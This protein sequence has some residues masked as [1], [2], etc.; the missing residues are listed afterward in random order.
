M[1]GRDVAFSVSSGDGS[2]QSAAATTDSNGVAT[3]WFIFGN[4]TA[5]VRAEAL[6]ALATY[7]FQEP[8]SSSCTCGHGNCAG[9]LCTGA[10]DPG[11]CVEGWLQ[12]E[13][14][15]R[16]ELGEG[17]SNAKWY[18]ICEPQKWESIKRFKRK[19]NLFGFYEQMRENGSATNFGHS[20]GY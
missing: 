2:L 9:A 17:K 1:S 7:T 12:F 13:E 15:A 8:T 5:T 6:G 18:L 16:L 4:H 11:T 19:T 14:F 3:V 10:A 20:P